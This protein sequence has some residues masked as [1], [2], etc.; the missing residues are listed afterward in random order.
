MEREQMA[1][2]PLVVVIGTD[3][4][5]SGVRVIYLLDRGHSDA[6][7]AFFARLG[8]LFHLVG[9]LFKNRPA[10]GHAGTALF[11]PCVQVFVRTSL[12]DGAHKLGVYLFDV[13]FV[14]NVQV[15]VQLEELLN[16][17]F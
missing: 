11:G 17:K 5:A 9:V 6:F 16:E 13:H 10:H 14:K 7:V 1:R 15:S 3:R 2:L 12:F 4:K 8:N